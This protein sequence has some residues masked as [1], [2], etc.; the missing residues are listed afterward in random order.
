MGFSFALQGVRLRVLL[1]AVSP[2][3]VG[4]LDPQAIPLCRDNAVGAG[5]AGAGYG[6]VAR[7]KPSAGRLSGC[8]R[9]SLR[10]D[11]GMISWRMPRIRQQGRRRWQP[12]EENKEDCPATISHASFSFGME[13]RVPRE[14]SSTRA[15]GPN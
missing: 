10:G 13:S 3:G 2:V 5:Q 7:S 15:V 4:G 14:C 12:R 9:V 1:P 6:L 11:R 8:L